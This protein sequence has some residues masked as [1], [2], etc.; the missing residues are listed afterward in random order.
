MTRIAEESGRGNIHGF[1][2]TTL[3]QDPTELLDEGAARLGVGD[4][5]GALDGLFAGLGAIRAEVEPKEWVQIREEARRHPILARLREDPLTD[6]AFRQPRGYPGDAELLDMI[7]DGP[8]H[9]SPREGTSDL[10]LAIFDRMVEAP[11]AQAVRDR[12]V[13]LGELV[14]EVATQRTDARV[15]SVAAGHLREVE[16]SRA[17]R[18]GALGEFVALDQDAQSLGRIESNPLN[19]APTRT[20]CAGVKELLEGRQELGTFDLVYSAGLYDYLNRRL[21]QSL[22]R[23]LFELVRPGGSLVI[24]N[25]LKDIPDAAFMETFLRWELIYRSDHDLRHLADA[26]PDEAIGRTTVHR[27]PGHQI[28][29]LR[30]TR[31]A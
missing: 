17:C 18:E 7:Y 3:V 8:E 21:A 19:L 1:G 29:Y 10:G 23:K 2:G 9:G 20:V 22:N 28:A 11:A 16:V 26:L 30:L 14:D 31:Y 27:D 6:H 15:L 13:I 25:F 24:F 5:V 4:V 12:R